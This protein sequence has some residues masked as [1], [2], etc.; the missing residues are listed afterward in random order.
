[1]PLITLPANRA[2]QGCR[3]SSSS[4]ASMCSISSDRLHVYIWRI[5]TKLSELLPYCSRPPAPVVEPARYAGCVRS[6]TP[7]SR[8]IVWLA[9]VRNNVLGVSSHKLRF[10]VP[11]NT[12]VP[13]L[14]TR[15]FRLCVLYSPS[16]RLMLSA[17]DFVSTITCHPVTRR[18]LVR[19]CT[20][21]VETRQSHCYHGNKWHGGRT[22]IVPNWERGRHW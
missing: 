15:P 14:S 11:V 12:V 8:D 18:L 2:I 20:T 19:P 9:S 22:N 3:F 7:A 16:D 13:L 6:S 5:T 4:R 10:T 17:E 1:M 21:R